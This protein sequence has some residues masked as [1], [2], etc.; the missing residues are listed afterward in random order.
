[1]KCTVNGVPRAKNRRSKQVRSPRAEPG[2]STQ[3]YYGTRQLAALAECLVRQGKLSLIHLDQPHAA[4]LSK[5]S[6]MGHLLD[7]SRSAYGRAPEQTEV[8]VRAER[9]RG[10][11]VVREHRP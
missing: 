4:A 10:P 9:T 8:R 6:E 7:Q 2:V 1:M 3:R 5:F 11:R